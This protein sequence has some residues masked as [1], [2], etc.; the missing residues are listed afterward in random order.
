MGRDLAPGTFGENL[1]IS[2]LECARFSIGD[3]LTV[4]AATLEV[5][6]A[7]IPCNTFARR[8]DD[9]HFIQRFREAERP[10]LYCRVLEEGSVQVG[11]DVSVEP[12]AGETVTLVEFY[13]AFYEKDLDEI[14]LR[15]LLE[16]PIAE[17]ARTIWEARLAEIT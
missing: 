7:R 13:R 1:T 10:G 12:Y 17:R 15:C 2:D 14:S 9:P 11:D 16:A 3:R 4:G 6:A 5:T 8:M